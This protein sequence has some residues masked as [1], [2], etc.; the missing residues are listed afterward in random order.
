M[1]LLADLV[2]SV[3]RTGRQRCAE[4]LTTHQSGKPLYSRRAQ[5]GLEALLGKFI[6]RKKGESW[7]GVSAGAPQG[8]VHV[9]LVPGSAGFFFNKLK[10]QRSSLL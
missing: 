7:A 3:G 2:K 1:S 6:H 5:E 4:F 8:P 10:M 9:H